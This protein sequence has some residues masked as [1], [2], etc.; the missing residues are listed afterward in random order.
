[1]RTPI[2]ERELLINGYVYNQDGTKA[3]K[4][5]VY[6]SDYSYMAKF[7]RFCKEYPEYWKLR[8]QNGIE[9]VGGDIVGKFYEVSLSCVLL[10]GK[11]RKGRTLTEAE[12]EASR[13]RMKQLHEAGVL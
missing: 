8:E 4:I 1:M 12:K 2:E 11:P 10:R 13:E 9:T 6:T 7:D 3:D 5:D